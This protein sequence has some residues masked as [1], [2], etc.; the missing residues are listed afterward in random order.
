M[1]EMYEAVV[2]GKPIV[3]DGRWAMAT[4]EI[5]NAKNREAPI[6]LRP[7]HQ[8]NHIEVGKI[9]RSPDLEVNGRVRII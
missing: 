8:S 5:G 4:L 3:H 7:Q 9:G 2:E 6:I 1:K